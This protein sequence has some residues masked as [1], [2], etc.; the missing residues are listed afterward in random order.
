MDFSEHEEEAV[1]PDDRQ[2]KYLAGML[3]MPLNAN[4][5]V[6]EPLVADLPEV[7][8]D[9]LRHSIFPSGSLSALNLQALGGCDGGSRFGTPASSR[10]ASPR[11]K[12]Q[13]IEHPPVA[14]SESASKR[15]PLVSPM[16][17][18][19]MPILSPQQFSCAENVC[20]CVYCKQFIRDNY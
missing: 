20:Q 1:E 14:R 3:T 7:T 5:C 17:P 12:R 9:D 11:M 18:V 6:T 4:D 8:L 13:K 15:E 2:Q 19:S 10:A 16:S